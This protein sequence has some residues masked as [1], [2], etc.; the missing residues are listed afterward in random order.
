M[1]TSES[2]NEVQVAVLVIDEPV[3]GVPFTK[4]HADGVFLK[5]G[6]KALETAGNEKLGYVLCGAHVHF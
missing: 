4:S 6:S 5:V 1:S 2:P 3:H